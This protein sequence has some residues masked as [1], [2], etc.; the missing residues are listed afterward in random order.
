MASAQVVSQPL[1]IATFD[2]GTTFSGY[3]FETVANL[4]ED[5]LQIHRYCWDL[6][7]GYV[8]TP[9]CVLFDPAQN[10]NS[11]GRD[12]EDKYT[13]LAQQNDHANWY[14]FRRFILDL[15]KCQV[16]FGISESCKVK[17]FVIFE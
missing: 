14:Y 15:Y 1:L 9:T 10:F 3:A 16:I 7:N 12:A 11:F 4:K 13:E 8:K 6:Q 17:H 5:I 2:F